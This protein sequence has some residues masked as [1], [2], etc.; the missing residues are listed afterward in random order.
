VEGAVAEAAT[1]LLRQGAPELLRFEVQ[2]ETAW[3]VGLTCGGRMEVFVE[4]VAASEAVLQTLCRAFEQE[5]PA[6]R[7]VVV[8]GPADLLGQSLLA[9]PAGEVVG[10]LEPA[11][12]KQL[13]PD[14]QV[15]LRNGTAASWVG[16]YDGEEV[17][18][19][20]DPVLPPATLVMVGGVHIAMSLSRLAK[21]L[22][23][24]VVVIDPRRRFATAERFPEADML[25]QQWPAEALQA[26]GPTPSTSIAVLSHDPKLDDP[27]L[28]AALRSPARY[29]GALGSRRT[30]TLRRKR[31]LEAGLTEQEL[32]RLHAPIGLDLGGQ[33]P[34][35]IA[36]SILA[37]IVA[38]RAVSP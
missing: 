1:R 28:L 9:Q 8:R 25:L 30:N 38:S 33:L 5:R 2:D 3:E 15:S 27:A 35:E 21:V 32:A 24:R 12:A 16:A 18:V 19:F 10:E 37:E 20:L 31:L 7:A 29:V 4:P 6:V 13:A 34:D 17:E 11:L 36:L 22:G 26:V 14:L 23:F